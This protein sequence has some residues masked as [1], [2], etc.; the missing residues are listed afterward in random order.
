MFQPITADIGRRGLIKGAAGAAMLGAGAMIAPKAAQAQTSG[1]IDLLNLVLNMEYLLTQFQGGALNISLAAARFTAG[2]APGVTVT[3][4]KVV[5]FSDPTLKSMLNEFANDNYNHLNP[6]RT[7]IGALAVGQPALD[8]GVGAGAAFSVAMQ[9]AGVVATGATFDPYANDENYLYALLLLKNTSVSAYRGLM[10]LIS[11]RTIVQNFA[12]LLGA[13]AIHAATIRS[14]LYTRSQLPNARNNADKIAAFQRTLNGGQAFQGITPSNR[15]YPG[16][17]S[18]QVR[19][20]NISPAGPGNG[21]LGRSAAQVLNQLY[22]TSAAASSGGFFP[23]GVNG[24]IRTSAAS[25]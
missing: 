9:R 11:N 2:A 19:V 13:E 6:I 24:N 17:G 12:G 16:G 8:I 4:A 21:V 1:D 10:P 25:A 7:V 18:A 15:G 14:Y 23:Q 20:A 5:N 22:L 3:G